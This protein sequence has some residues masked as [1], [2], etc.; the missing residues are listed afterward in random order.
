[1]EGLV[2]YV[3]ESAR[4]RSLR[5]EGKLSR[6]EMERQAETLLDEAFPPEPLPGSLILV[7]EMGRRILEIIVSGHTRGS[8]GFIQA[9]LGDTPIGDLSE[10]ALYLL[11]M[12]RREEGALPRLQLEAF[13]RQLIDPQARQAVETFL[14]S[15][16]VENGDKILQ[17]REVLEHLP[18]FEP[19]LEF[20]VTRNKPQLYEVRELPRS[21]KRRNQN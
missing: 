1:M 4:L 21:I 15:I 18:E 17:I 12:A 19:T 16:L 8:T 9:M 14:D 20:I 5:A 7:G 13:Y 11:D 3:Q 10:R 2:H 6:P